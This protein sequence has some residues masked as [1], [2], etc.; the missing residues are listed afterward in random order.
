MCLS[1]PE[2]C[3]ENQPGSYKV[4]Q[5]YVNA[6]LPN[7]L[8]R[9]ISLRVSDVSVS[10]R[11]V[12]LYSSLELYLMTGQLNKLTAQHK[13]IDDIIDCIKIRVP[14]E[15]RWHLNTLEFKV[16]RAGINT[17]HTIICLFHQENRRKPHV[18]GY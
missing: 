15:D 5:H 3:W 16:L 2:R 17:K 11:T 7:S 18:T 8:L 10:I 1:L 6:K 14:K 4:Q 12:L 9:N 13:H